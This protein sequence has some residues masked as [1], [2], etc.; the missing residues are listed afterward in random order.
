ML[1]RKLPDML[2][3]PE[4]RLA[5][6]VPLA[7]ARVGRIVVVVVALVAG[8]RVGL[9]LDSIVGIALSPCTP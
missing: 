9:L 2:L 1:E 3:E 6:V 8:M 7:V 5:L 4:Q